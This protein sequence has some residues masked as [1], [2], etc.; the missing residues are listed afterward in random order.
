MNKYFE[1]KNRALANAIFYITDK[2]YM[3]FDNEDGSKRYSFINCDEVY[4]AF[5]NIKKLKY[6]D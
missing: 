4:K 1:V 2:S 6:N 5:N 3:I